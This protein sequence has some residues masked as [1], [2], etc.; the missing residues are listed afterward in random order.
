MTRVSDLT[1]ADEDAAER[2]LLM[3]LRDGDEAAYMELVERLSPSM[4]RVAR[5]YVPT[6][7]VAEDVVQETWLAVLNGLDRFEGRSSVKTWIFTILM[8][9]AKTRGTRERRTVP[10]ASLAGA[11][12]SDDF[13]AV[14]P[15]RFLPADHDR[16]P[17]AWAA[18]PRRWDEDPE[19][20][21]Q[22]SETLDIV[23]K[24]IAQL[25][26]MQRTVI[27]M[28][29][30]EGFTAE[31]VRNVLEI[32]ETNQRVLLHR[33]RAKVRAALEEHLTP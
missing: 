5:G 18:P 22:S 1:I 24:A 26:E 10:F 17:G 4:L 12:A 9:R 2:A 23:K 16:Y 20:S 28:R 31:E 6:Q 14:E 3:R 15:E 8:N 27:T 32:S 13:S 33:A 25:P 30:L 7:A 11:E 21:L 19:L 29:D